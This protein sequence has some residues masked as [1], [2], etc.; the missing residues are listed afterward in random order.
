MTRFTPSVKYKRRSRSLLEEGGREAAQ[1]SSKILMGVINASNEVL[2]N[3]LR[4]FYVINLL[5]F[6]ILNII[7]L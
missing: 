4:K 1:M 2:D 6:K 3:C 5:T 7:I